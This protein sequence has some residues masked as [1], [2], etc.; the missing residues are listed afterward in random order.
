[1]SI[2]KWTPFMEPFGDMDRFFE[3]F[4]RGGVGSFSP[5][6]D[7]YE[8]GNNVIVEAQLPGLEA[9]Q[10][11]VSVENDTLTIQG[12]MEKKSEVDEK[13]YYRKEIHT[14]SFYRAVALPAHV[15]GAKTKAEF[16]DGVLLVTVP[17]LKVE[18]AK[19]VKVIAKKTK[20]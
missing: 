9:D 5:A 6:M 13:N 3:E 8:K 11:E 4:R 10:V 14:G 18:A 1:M 2:I 7:V 19:K 12:K 16:A 17:K 20:K 15:D